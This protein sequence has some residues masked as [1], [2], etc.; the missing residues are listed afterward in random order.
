MG[1]T[2]V[3]V[4]MANLTDED[5][6]IESL[7]LVDT[8]AIDCV[9]ASSELEK[10]GVI[11]QGKDVYELA[12]GTTTEYSYG[13]VTVELMGAKTVVQVVFG[14]EG[15]EP[16]LGGVALENIGIGVD[17][18]SKSLKKMVAKPLK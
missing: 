13:F 9:L 1:L 17:P 6:F 7:F 4:K 11:V 5:K 2:R 12:D 8:G 15:V 18:I 10:I 14:P 3:T 16:L